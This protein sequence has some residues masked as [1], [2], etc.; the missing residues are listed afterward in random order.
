MSSIICMEQRSCSSPSVRHSMHLSASTLS[1]LQPPLLSKAGWERFLKT[2]SLFTSAGY[3]TEYIFITCWSMDT[4]VNTLRSSGI[5]CTWR[6]I[7]KHLWRKDSLN[8]FL[9]QP[10]PSLYLPLPMSLSKKDFWCSGN[11]FHMLKRRVLIQIY[12][13]LLLKLLYKEYSK[14]TFI[15]LYRYNTFIA[16]YI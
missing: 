4:G 9:F 7:L 3:H 15:F 13:E 2:N 12:R 10:A 6:I 11:T 1:E 5:T 16:R 14:N 8:L